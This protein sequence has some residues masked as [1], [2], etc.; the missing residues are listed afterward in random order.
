MQSIRRRLSI[1]LVFCT[2]AGILLTSLVVNL[3][4]NNKFNRYMIDTQNKRYERIVGSFQDIYKRDGKWTK[5]SGI[6]MMHDAYMSN[7]CLTLLDKD[8]KVVWGM[9]PNDI[10]ER[11]HISS[12]QN[13]KDGIYTS[14]QFEIKVDGN[15]VGYVDIGQYSSVLLSQED[16]NFISSINSSVVVS[17]IAVLI[18]AILIS[19]FFSKQFSLPIKDIS[20]MSVNLSQGKFDARSSTKSNILELEYLRQSVNTLAE[21][22]KQQDMLRKRLVSD[23]SHEI[24]TPLN[25]L[26]NNLEAMIDG[27]FPASN[28]RLISLNEEVIRFGKL[29]DNLNVLKEFETE[30]NSMNI[31]KVK[32][33]EII[34]T[35]IQD[36]ETALKE[37]DIVLTCNIQQNKDFSI[38]GDKDKLKQVFIN[39]L[40]NAIKFNN[41]G[42]RVWINV[43]EQENKIIVKVGD[44]GIG[45]KDEDLP[46]IF[47]RL[48]RG[49]KSRHNIEGSGIGLTIVEKILKMHSASITAESQEGK[50][51][52]FKIFLKK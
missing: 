41:A 30:G 13:N 37:K 33:D 35:V 17:S 9:D 46:F 19:L 11:I 36:F 1:I 31:E 40:S 48:Y 32:L 51:T 15:T 26:Q 49:D 10:Q 50:G 43:S 47:E 12:M 5:N 44:T 39:I 28:E 38:L 27:I 16:V 42:G 8:K 14:K 20:N 52:I 2:V 7:Y 24:R 29:L 18:I 22:L 6:E 4:I 23:I 34:R 3:T 21:K 25:V 45:I